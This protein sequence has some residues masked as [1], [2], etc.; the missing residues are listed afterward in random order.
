MER[1]EIAP[2]KVSSMHGSANPA[3]SKL[4]Q[5]AMQPVSYYLPARRI[6]TSL[7]LRALC[8]VTREGV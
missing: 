4:K 8:C 2:Q 6:G 7:T 3:K 5:L 1:V